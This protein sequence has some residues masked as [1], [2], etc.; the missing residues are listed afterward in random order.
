LA[1]AG[2]SLDSL[3]EAITEVKVVGE[4]EL[5]AK[6]DTSQAVSAGSQFSVALRATSP[7]ASATRSQSTARTNSASESVRRSGEERLYVTFGSTGAAFRRIVDLLQGHRLWVLL[8]EWSSVP[9]VLQPYLADLLRR[10]I[11]PITG[12]TVKVAAI[13]QRSHFHV[14]SDHGDY[15]GIEVGADASADVSL[16]DFMVFDNDEERAKAFFRSLVV[17]HTGAVL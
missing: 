2:P 6:A 15:V 12:I 9:I 7:E 16:D 14:R 5:S 17:R 13:E 1:Q 4:V 10:S 8:D 3:A 11:F